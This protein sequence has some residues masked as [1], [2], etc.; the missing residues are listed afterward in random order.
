MGQH[1]INNKDFYLPY[2]EEA[3]FVSSYTYPDLY[4]VGERRRLA[5]R[6]YIRIRREVQLP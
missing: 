4:K 5:Q 6:R 3:K 1:N 2:F